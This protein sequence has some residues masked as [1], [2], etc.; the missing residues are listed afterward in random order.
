MASAPS[1]RSTSV[2]SA[3]W[4]DPDQNPERAISCLGGD[5]L[6]TGVVTKYGQVHFGQG[7][8]GKHL[9]NV[10]RLHPGNGL[11]RAQHRLGTEAAAAIE[12]IRR[13]RIVAHV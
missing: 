1:K 7:I 10:A 8:G 2:W 9:Q 3:P 13:Y 11:A 4:T 6:V 12:N 5:K